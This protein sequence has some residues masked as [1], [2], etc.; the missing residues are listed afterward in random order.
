M[1]TERQAFGY[2]VVAL[3]AMSVCT[4]CLGIVLGA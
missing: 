3:V 4:S 1:T 2:L